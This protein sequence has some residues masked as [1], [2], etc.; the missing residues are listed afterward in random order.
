[1]GIDLGTT[2]SSLAYLDSQQVPCVVSDTSGHTVIPSVIYFDDESIIVGDTALELSKQ[3]SARAVQF[4]KLH[5]GDEWRVRINGHEHTP[6][7]L[8][9][10]ILAHLIREAEPQLGPLRQAVITVPAWFTEKRRRATE[11]AG[12]IA[13]LDVTGTLNE[14][15]AAAL[16]YGLHRTD[17]AQGH[18]PAKDRNVLV[19]DLGGGTF[20]V[21]LMRITPAELVELATRGN[22]KLGG[23]DWDELLMKLA[24]DDFRRGKHGGTAAARQAADQL[25]H[26]ITDSGASKDLA[27]ELLN[28]LHDLRLEC[29]RAKRR[30]SSAAKT[31]IPVRLIGF[32]HSAEITRAQFES[33]AE[34]LVQSTRMT[35]ETALDDAKLNW[36]QLDRVVLVG[37]STHMPMV[38]QML[39]QVSGKPP[40]R[41]INPVT[42][43]A[44]GAAIYASQLETGRT[45]RAIRLTKN[46]ADET[47]AATPLPTS[48]DQP[49]VQFVTAHGIGIRTTSANAAIN[50]VLIHRN[51]AVPTT[52]SRRFRTKR[53]RT[54][55]ASGIRVVVTQ[56][57]TPDASLAEV[58][59]TARITGIPPDD[60]PGQPVDITLEFDPHSRLHLRA[61]YVNTGQ[62]LALDLDVPGGLREEQVEQYRELLVNS[63]LV[64]PLPPPATD[65]N[66]LSLDDD[67]PDDD[68]EEPLLEPID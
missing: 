21:T 8:S 55:P 10:M 34:P 61:L 5:M 2:Y 43:V 7:S 63:G 6:E 17:D 23:K 33:V 19:Y 9:A 20:D 44:L 27:P 60:P 13:G 14:P 29:E 46:E 39:Q 37:G 31:A 67:F 66:V 30:L 40:D 1:V 11:Q 58:L 48:V 25:A 65:A 53:D 57:D 12:R 18:A 56:G 68:E 45:L 62:L 3:N 47:R 26:C 59:G 42:A 52:V 16:A 22:R 28:A 41:G 36:S 51:T 15:M 54:G 64:H 24:L 49:K 4:V 38:R 50:N 35:V 32:D